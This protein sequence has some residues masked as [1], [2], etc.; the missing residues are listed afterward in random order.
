MT[1]LLWIAIAALGCW[2]VY[3]EIKLRACESILD[4]KHQDQ[5]RGMEQLS[6][7]LAEI[8]IAKTDEAV[9]ASLDAQRETC[10]EWM[11]ETTD[12]MQKMKGLL[13]TE[14]ARISGAHG[15]IMTLHDSIKTETAKREAL[16]ETTGK[17]MAAPQPVMLNMEGIYQAMCNRA[18]MEHD[19]DSVFR[20]A[21][22][23]DWEGGCGDH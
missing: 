7:K 4:A 17:Y 20:Q 3:V 23:K 1:E 21:E 22:G 6:D 8:F 12:A 19:P 13:A 5:I 14:S 18:S 16:E 11:Q 10:L 9:D 2:N 15:S